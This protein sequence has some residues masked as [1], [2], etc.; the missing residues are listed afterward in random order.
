MQL[1]PAQGEDRLCGDRAWCLLEEPLP[2]RPLRRHGYLLADDMMDN[3]GKQIRVHLA[4]D[5]A[6]ALNGRSQLSVFG[7]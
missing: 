6:D 7:A 4:A 5:M 2:N 1:F 3:R